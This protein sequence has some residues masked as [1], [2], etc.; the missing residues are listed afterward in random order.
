MG[1]L[2]PRGPASHD[3]AACAAKATSHPALKN[4]KKGL[5]ARSPSVATRTDP[6]GPAGTLHA[7]TR[8]LCRGPAISKERSN[9]KPPGLKDA[10]SRRA[11]HG[12]PEVTASNRI[13]PKRTKSKRLPAKRQE[14]SAGPFETWYMLWACATLKQPP[15]HVQPG[16]APHTDSAQTKE[17][18]RDADFFRLTKE[19]ALET[20]SSARFSKRLSRKDVARASDTIDGCTTGASPGC[21]SG[22][23][24]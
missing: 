14:E 5:P 6:K 7:C 10:R 20:R 21:T 23:T 2:A 15:A 1:P 17:P 13:G 4:T 11:L 9:S 24:L 16:S 22:S 8:V 18:T 3:P 19:P 12:W